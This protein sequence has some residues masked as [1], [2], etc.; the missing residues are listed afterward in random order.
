MFSKAARLGPGNESTRKKIRPFS[1]HRRKAK[2]IDIDGE[3][4]IRSVAFLAGGRHVVSGGV[5][6][7]IRCWRVDNGEEVGMPMDA[8]STV[9]TIAV[10]LDGKWVVSGTNSGRVTVWNAESHEKVIGL[11][12]HDDWVRA[13]D[14]SPDASRIAT[15]SYDKTACVWSLSTGHR[16]LDPLQHDWSLAAVKFSPDGRLLA[17]ATWCRSSLRIYDSATGRLLTEFPIQVS[18]SENQSLAWAS[19]SMHLFA[20][21]RDG[22][23][24][25]LDVNNGTMLSRWPIHSNNNSRCIALASD[26]QSIAASAGSSVSFWDTTTQKQVGSVIQHPALVVSVAISERYD[27]V[28]GGGK[29]IALQNIYDVLHASGNK[30]DTRSLAS[31]ADK[32]LCRLLQIFP[33]HAMRRTRGEQAELEETGGSSHTQDEGQSEQK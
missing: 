23:I 18:S 30:E 27:L 17:T 11:V 2:M 31:K 24:N 21:S 5:E 6:G 10:S 19:D 25:R 28:I 15:G 4:S 8:W 29:Q 9:C 3:G 7:K 32:F 20:L 16:L 1:S 22:N 13:V 14:V 12:G 26:C 33:D